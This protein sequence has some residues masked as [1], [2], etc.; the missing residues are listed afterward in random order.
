MKK[1]MQIN[2]T[3]GCGSTGR[4]AK[5]LYEACIEQGFEAAFCYSWA[6]ATIPEAFRIETQWQNIKRRALN[7]WFGKKQKHSN[8]GTKRLIKYIERQKPDLIHLHNIHLN[9]LNYPM[10]FAYLKKKNIPIV[11]TLHDCWSFTGGCYHFSEIGCDKY[12]ENCT[13]CTNIGKTDDV[14]VGTEKTYALKRDLI[15]GNENIKIVCVS[16]WLADCARRSYMKNMDVRTI[17]NGID[18]TIFHYVE[19]QKRR[20]LSIETSFV[21]LGVAN[22]WDDKKGLADFKKLRQSLGAEYTIVLVGLSERQKM[23]LPSGIIGV[24]RTKDTTELVQFY[25]MADVYVNTSK[26]ETF[27]LT[28]AEAMACG[29]PVVVY[30]KTA[31]PEIPDVHSGIVVQDV[32]EMEKAIL[33]ICSKGKNAYREHCIAR[34]REHFQI[35]SMKRQ[36]MSIYRSI[37]HEREN[38]S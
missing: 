2:I 9:M 21:I 3:C 18:T 17:Y 8:A 15:S 22:I 1:I 28:T 20:E 14:T 16:K 31:L 25:S 7:R 26:E 12:G 24:G 33:E 29:T 36:Y 11:Y 13:G 37:L 27:G 34:V 6:N 4:L 32:A 10:F 19:S 5:S 30:N 38:Q 23:D 35:V